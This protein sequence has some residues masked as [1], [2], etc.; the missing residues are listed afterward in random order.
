MVKICSEVDGLLK[1]LS[2][3]YGMHKYEVVEMLITEDYAGEDVFKVRLNSQAEFDLRKL[4]EESGMNKEDF[5]TDLLR[6]LNS[7]FVVVRALEVNDMLN[8]TDRQ[9]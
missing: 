5:L 9:I 1:T 7:Y 6:K 4:A 8:K 2:A 3:Q